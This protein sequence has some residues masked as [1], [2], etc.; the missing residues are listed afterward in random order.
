[1]VGAG[2]A[3]A[4]GVTFCVP[5]AAGKSFLTPVKG[6]CRKGYTRTQ[7]G[8]EG[9]QGGE[10]KQGAEGKQGNTVLSEPEQKALK[11]I[12]PYVKFSA[13]GV[14][15]KPTIQFSGVNVQILNGEGKTASKNG[16]GNLIVGYDETPGT[17]TGSHNVVLGTEG[18]IYTSWGS[19]L[20]GTSNAAT[21][22]YSSVTGGGR[23]TASG[24]DSS[25]SGGEI[26]TASSLWSAVSGGGGN[27]ASFEFSSVSGGAGSTASG[28]FSSVSGG[29]E[30]AATQGDSSVSGGQKNAASALFSSVSGGESNEAIWTGSSIFGGKA[31]I[32]KAVYDAIP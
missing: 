28:E 3:M 15:G 29:D 30:N 14:G 13:S 17:Q 26:N 7:L 1:M 23:N 19:L 22:E 16:A 18:Q 5:K 11:A 10:G 31:L 2:G 4:A 32:T 27:T 6:K 12:L 24:E 20:A 25:V 21:G 9:K 8:S